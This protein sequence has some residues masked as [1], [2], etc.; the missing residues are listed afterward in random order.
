MKPVE[1]HRDWWSEKDYYDRRKI[2]ARWKALGSVLG[3]IA[4]VIVAYII[5]RAIIADERRIDREHKE[6]MVVYCASLNAEHVVDP[7]GTDTCQRGPD[8]VWRS[9]E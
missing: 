2:K 9:E 8:L 6:E 1:W 5:V 4:V 3:V 7:Y